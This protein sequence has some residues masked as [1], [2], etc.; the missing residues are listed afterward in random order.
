MRE[1]IANAAA[2]QVDD[3]ILLAAGE[4]HTA[5]KGIGALRTN[6][7]GFEQLFQGVAVGL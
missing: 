1:G 5:A 3:V 4:D 7:A 2:I 6:Q